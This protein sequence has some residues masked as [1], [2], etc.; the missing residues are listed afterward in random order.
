MSINPARRLGNWAITKYQNYVS[1][2]LADDRDYSCKYTPSCSHYGQDAVKE[3]GLIKGGKM[4]F[5]RMMRCHKS[6]EGGY[7][8]VI[9]KEDLGKASNPK[10]AHLNYKYENA[11]EIFA[12]QSKHKKSSGGIKTIK[13]NLSEKPAGIK[14]YARHAFKS[15][16]KTATTLIGGAA[17]ATL[18]TAV[19]TPMGTYLGYKAGRNEIDEVNANIAGKYSPE[20]V[21][22]FGKIE[23]ALAKPA[24]KINRIIEKHTGNPTLARIAGGVIGG[25]IGLALGIVKGARKGFQT[26]AQY[27]RLFGTML[28]SDKPAKK[29][30]YPPTDV[31]IEDMSD[32][33]KGK[34]SFDVGGTRITPITKKDID[35]SFI[36]FI[37]SAKKSI[38]IDLFSIKSHKMKDLLVKKA[39]EGVKIR[40]VTN[41]GGR[42][43][44]QQEQNKVVLDELKQ[45]GI[46]VKL[47]PRLKA[48][49]QF[50]HSKMIIVDNKAASI[51]TRNW[52]YSFGNDD[53]FDTM[54]YMTGDTVDEARTFFERDYGIAGGNPEKVKHEDQSPGVKILGNEPLRTDITKDLK[55]SIKNA[56]ESI[57]LSVY[58]L[59]DKSILGLLNKA[60][61]RGVNMKVILANT[62]QN[63][64]AN[65]Y[66]KEKG[67]EVRTFKPPQTDKI[68]SHFHEKMAIFDDHH[69]TMGSCDL[70]PQGLYS[71]REINV[72]ID[73]KDLAEYMKAEFQDDWKNFSTV[74]GSFKPSREDKLIKKKGIKNHILDLSERAPSSIQQAGALL[75]S[76]TSIAKRFFV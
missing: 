11:E 39:G 29:K 28:T 53:D 38:D 42:L 12:R 23:N 75:V 48:M 49:N 65:N 57:N 36:K 73:N 62:L 8:P 5:M 33:F 34:R 15:C 64:Y 59:T 47:Y 54:F 24:H 51:G 32:F 16:I 17:G 18:F 45:A 71:N 20:S 46:D 69:V 44:S 76:M 22:G 72:S 68:R 43:Q 13:S 55:K 66:L 63:K 35:P 37:E 25:P 58:W 74:K 40:V 2:S 9:P 6:A 26:G 3:Y 56:K 10:P 30:V 41:L 19:G 50:N 1:S 31:K 7:D 70:T 52:G 21:Y 61:K 4:S 67:I 14:G 60:K 27:G